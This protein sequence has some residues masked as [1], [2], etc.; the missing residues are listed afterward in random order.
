MLNSIYFSENHV[1]FCRE[2]KIEFQV[3]EVLLYYYS[4]TTMQ[5]CFVVC[6][7]IVN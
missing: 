2:C 1:Y 4:G 7:K 6:S 5:S 3:Q